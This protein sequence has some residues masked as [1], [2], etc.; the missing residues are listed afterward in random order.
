M[1]LIDMQANPSTG[2][3]GDIFRWLLVGRKGLS[4][5]ATFR[6]LRTKCMAEVVYEVIHMWQAAGGSE[7][8]RYITARIYH[9]I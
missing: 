2:F 8:I 5:F 3:Q 6:A 9:Y 7:K 1:D 4:K